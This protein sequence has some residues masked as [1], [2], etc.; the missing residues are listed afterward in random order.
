MPTQ[1]LN[2]SELI[3]RLGLKAST[4]LP[5]VERIQPTLPVISA[6]TLAPLLIG[7]SGVTGSSAVIVPVGD[8]T[9]EVHAIAPGGGLVRAFSW[10]STG[11]QAAAFT[12]TP[13]RLAI[14]GGVAAPLARLTREA[15]VALVQVGDGPAGALIGANGVGQLQSADVGNK[16]LPGSSGGTF[17]LPVPPGEFFYFAITGNVLIWSL[18][19]QDLPAADLIPAPA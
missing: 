19:W 12:V 13:T 11:A 16:G 6:E 4:S 14:A 1:G 7:A 18:V 8:L 15:P 2:V 5:L 9:M 10:A 17:T 3:K